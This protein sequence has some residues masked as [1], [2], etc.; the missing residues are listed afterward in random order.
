MSYV[1]FARKY[2]PKR[3]SEVVGQDSLV[4]IL[5]NGVRVK[6]ISSA[7]LFF[8]P[9]GV[10]KTT[11]A[12]ILAKS[13]NCKNPREGEPCLE[14]E[15]CKEIERGSFPD[16][17]ELDAASNRG[18][19]EIRDLKERIT[20]RPVKGKYK[21]YIIDE[22]HMLT[23]EAFNALLKTLEEPPPNTLFI[24]CTTEYEKIPPTI[25]SR[26]QR[27]AFSRIEEGKV[28]SFL[29]EVC[30]RE[31]IEYQEEALGQI[32]KLSEGCMRDALSLLDQAS[33]YGEGKVSLKELEGLLGIVSEGK[34]FDFFK[35]LLKGK[36][37]EALDFLDE[38]YERGI[39]LQRFW[40]NLESMVFDALLFKATGDAELLK[41]RP[42]LEEVKGSLSELLYLENLISRAKLELRT[43]PPL[44]A[45]KV[46]VI[47]TYLLK[48][49]IPILSLN[50]K[51]E[52]PKDE[53]RKKDFLEDVKE[54]FSAKILKEENEG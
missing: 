35:L 48:E 36:V 15:N 33:T 8:G 34:V 50:L 31:N 17:I 41:K 11:L 54:R 7:Y 18:I 28:V 19:D 32:A 3:F 43:R 30:R 24:L 47:K 26:C 13:L 49:V 9:R 1:P 2:R 46:S 23:K 5:R 22:A 45:Y 53:E 20:Y 10:G 38:L 37:R 27:F 12:R 42:Y 6:R 4:K 25:I 16:L 52:K 44:R 40:E 21:V 14:C 51:V 39:N 29:K